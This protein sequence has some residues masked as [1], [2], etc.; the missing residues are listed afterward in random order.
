M[1]DTKKQE[2]DFTEERKKS[3]G[4]P[5]NTQQNAREAKDFTAVCKGWAVKGGG[6]PNMKE[7]VQ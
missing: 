2:R 5:I 7:L 3:I 1:L 4:I 6:G